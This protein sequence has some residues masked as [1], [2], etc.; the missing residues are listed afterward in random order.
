MIELYDVFGDTFR[1]AIGYIDNNA[2]TEI[3]AKDSQRS[4]F[5]VCQVLYFFY[6]SM[7]LWNVE[8][9]SRVKLTEVQYEYIKAG[10][11]YGNYHSKLV[12]FE[13]QKIIS[14]LKSPSLERFSP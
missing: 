7:Y 1:D 11:H 13:S 14:I 9:E 8:P 5:Q 4:V 12:H 10:L 2:V 3:T 6:H